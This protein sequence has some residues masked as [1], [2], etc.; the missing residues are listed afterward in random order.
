MAT[1]LE[2]LKASPKTFNQLLQET[3]AE[4]ST[5]YLM[6]VAL[7]RSGLVSKESKKKPFALDTSF[8]KRMDEYSAWWNN[9]VK[10]K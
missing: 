1:V 3:K 10:A 7:Q 5:L 8:S 6:C 9:W 4:K 2:S